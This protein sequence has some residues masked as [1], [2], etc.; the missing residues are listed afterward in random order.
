MVNPEF[1]DDKWGLFNVERQ[2]RFVIQNL[3]PKSQWAPGDYTLADAVFAPTVVSQEITA[4]R[5]TVYADLPTEGEAIAPVQRW[6]GFDSP[7]N[8][9]VGE[10]MDATLAFEGVHFQEVGPVPAVYGWGALT[11]NGNPPSTV[12]VSTSTCSS[13]PVGSTSASRPPTPAN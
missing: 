13:P 12:A 10:G 3:F 7:P 6:D 4:D 2:A 1:D 11:S 8:A 9:F 5:Y